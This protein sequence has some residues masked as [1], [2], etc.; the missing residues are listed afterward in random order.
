MLGLTSSLEHRLSDITY[1]FVAKYLQESWEKDT[2]MA[3]V[4]QD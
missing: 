3:F 1:Y 2:R 4:L